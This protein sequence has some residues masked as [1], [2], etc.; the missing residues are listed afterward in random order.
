MRN[1]VL[2]ENI[3]EIRNL[4]RQTPTLLNQTDSYRM[5]LLHH[6][7]LNDKDKSVETLLNYEVRL[8]INAAINCPGHTNH[9]KTAL[10]LVKYRQNSNK[11]I[12]VRLL[13]TKRAIS[14]IDKLRD[15]L[16]TL[17]DIIN[18]P[19]WKDEGWGLFSNHIPP[20]VKKMQDQLI[21]DWAWSAADRIKTLTYE[22]MQ[23]IIHDLKQH[24]PS[25]QDGNRKDS[26]KNLYNIINHLELG[27]D[28]DFE[29]LHAFR[30]NQPSDNN[31]QRKTV[32]LGNH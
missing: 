13:T 25:N 20:G 19:A 16:T 7:V 3:H 28:I 2:T 17:V 6:A 26:T 27:C 22:A 4:L 23:K 15:D 29:P 14:H 1:A 11:V 5:T 24:I 30:N 18:H 12:Q 9:G 10:D 21:K 31:V 32:V 8:N